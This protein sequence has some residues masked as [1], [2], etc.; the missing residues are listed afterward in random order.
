MSNFTSSEASIVPMSASAALEEV[1]RRPGVY[2]YYPAIFSRRA[3]GLFNGT[4]PS[5]DSIDSAKALL[6]YKASLYL[7]LRRE[8]LYEGY[9][10]DKMR[11]PHLA[12][13]FTVHLQE[14]IN[15]E[16]VGTL[17]S[18]SAEEFLRALD[19]L[20][21]TYFLQ[22]P[23]YVGISKEQT[24]QTRCIQHMRNYQTPSESDSFGGR[25]RRTGFDWSD[26]TFVGVPSTTYGDDLKQAE[27]ILH[28]IVNPILSL[29]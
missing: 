6:R 1:P 3:L 14:R 26:L 22:S 15:E 10:R 28:L 27:K 24:L 18:L 19:F 21:K 23:L 8:R 7:K 25:L 20:E 9:L 17:L 29:R 4:Q 12:P 2:A 5:R 13:T 16:P 11:H